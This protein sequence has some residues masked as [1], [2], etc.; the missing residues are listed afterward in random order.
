MLKKRPLINCDLG[1][2][3]FKIDQTLMPLIAMANIACGGHVGDKQSMTKAVALAKKHQVL[4]GAHL[5]YVDRNNFGRRHITINLKTLSGQLDKQIKALKLICDK[6]AVLLSYIKPH[7]ALYHDILSDMGLL[8][9]LL[10]LIAKSQ[11]PLFLV[12]QANINTQ[13]IQTLSKQ[14]GVSLFYEAFADRAYVGHQ[15]MSRSQKNAVLT[16]AE[17]IIKQFNDWQD[18]PDKLIDTICF[19]SDNPASIEALKLLQDSVTNPQ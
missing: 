2:C 17:Q 19:H 3:G 8:D 10:N 14:Y 9:L 4:V 1:E 11:L 16:S 18:C 7:G 13:A 15:L 6:Q 12:V 5:S